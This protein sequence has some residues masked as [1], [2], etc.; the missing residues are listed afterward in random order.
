MGGTQDGVI[1]KSSFRYGIEAGDAMAPVVRTFEEAVIG[2]R[3][4]CYLVLVE[5]ANHFAIADALDGTTGRPF[6]DFDAT[7]PSET[8]RT[9]IADTIGLFID[10]QVRHRSEAAE[11]LHQLSSNPLIR[12]FA[13]K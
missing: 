1:A 2:G 12:S 6:L 4:D 5:G 11:P 9:L 13:C 7:Q 10:A 3:Q 8:L